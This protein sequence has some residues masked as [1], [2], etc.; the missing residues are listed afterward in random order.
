MTS[1]DPAKL[2]TA[3][4]LDGQIITDDGPVV[5]DHVYETHTCFVFLDTTRA[6]KVRKPIDLGFLDYRT[7]P[8]RYYCSWIPKARCAI[9]G[10][11]AVFYHSCCWIWN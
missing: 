1:G 5:V 11:W 4:W 8:A 6:Y 10:R 3:P 9:S 2:M 7:L